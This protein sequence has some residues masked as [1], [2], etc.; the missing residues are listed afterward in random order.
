[1]TDA[2]P[3][4]RG[5]A[6]V[7]S[8]AL[9]C[10]CALLSMSGCPGG[11]RMDAGGSFTVMTYNV[12]YGMPSHDR[13]VEIIRQADVDVVCLQETTPEW[14][15][16]LRREFDG[17]YRHIRFKHQSGAGGQGVLSKVPFRQVYHR[18]PADA[19]HPGW[20]IRA[21]TPAGPVQLLNVH[22]RP[23]VAKGSDGVYRFALTAWFTSRKVR[24]AQITEMLGWTDLA[25]PTVIHLVCMQPQGLP[26]RHG[27]VRSGLQHVAVAPGPVRHPPAP[28]PRPVQPPP[29]LHGRTGDPRRRVR[30]PGGGGDV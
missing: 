30:S 19:W 3:R 7:P 2:P 21:H 8:L 16:L 28:G 25:R 10:L 24:R 4:R 29:A 5:A 1:M 14:E 12:N 6:S 23:P 18:R 26:Q 27:R 13:T 20:M 17:R 22:L 15:T 11:V 9:A